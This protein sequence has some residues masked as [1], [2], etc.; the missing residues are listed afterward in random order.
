M[1]PPCMG[2][3]GEFEVTDFSKLYD[4]VDYITRCNVLVVY[5]LHSL[6][7]LVVLTG[8][9]FDAFVLVKVKASQKIAF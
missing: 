8:G 4:K 9:I 5:F 3:G 6:G 7:E 1:Q 2:Y